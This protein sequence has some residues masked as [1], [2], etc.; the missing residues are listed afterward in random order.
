MAM[1]RE[2]FE[3]L[4]QQLEVQ[5]RDRPAAYER[6][7]MALALLGNA[8]LAAM[9]ALIGLLLVAAVASVVKLGVI[10]VKIALVVG[11]FLAVV[12]QALWVKVPPPDGI[13]IKPADA[14]E[15]FKLIENLRTTLGAPRFHHVLIN[16]DFNAAVVQSPRLGLFGW[17]RN[18]LLIGLPLIKLLSVEQFRAVLAHEFGHLAK[19]HGRMSNWIY[20]LR[21]RW[22]RLV[23][24]LEE[25]ESYGTF[26]FRPFL[27]W[28][29]PYFDAYSYPL[30]RANE[31][32]ADATSARLTS[33][34]AAAEALTG[35]SVYASYLSERFWP[36]IYRQADELPQPAFAP[37]AMLSGRVAVEL[38]ETA[39]ADWL[40]HA[41]AQ[42]TTVDDTHPALHERLAALGEPP[43]LALPAPGKTADRLL[44]PAL[45]A[46]TADFDQRWYQTVLPSWQERHREVQD[47]RSRL[48][49]L[50]ALH[51][52]AQALSPS[53]SIERA[54]LTESVGGDANSALAQ[55]Q[56]LHADG[57]DSAELLHA[58]GARLLALG[59]G[60]GQTML[61]RA[62]AL[63]EHRI[64]AI[65]ELLR[66]DHWQAG[67]EAEAQAWHQRLL[68]RAELEQLAAKERNVLR[69]NE[70]FD[71]HGLSEAQ[72]KELREQLRAVP[73]VR[74]AYLVRKR[75]KHLPH[76]PCHVLGYTAKRAFRFD[77]QQRIA[78]A[79]AGIQTSV[80]LP[81]ETL[82]VNVE[83]ENYRL[84]RTLWWMRGARLL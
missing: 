56:A 67:R 17:D 16:E 3:A 75:V 18:Y 41:L 76:L 81:G 27:R 2:Q 40:R 65:C 47:G 22:G 12:L 79:L 36:G 46:I 8:Y 48:A 71:A 42:R 38:N 66:D 50:N 31:F 64:T 84:G 53:E 14:P 26:L 1:T 10:G 20:R 52:A 21:L 30:A 15:L 45:A 4:V 33:P 83:G 72:L 35:V 49:S 32:Q 5:A 55:L 60:S 61:E 34:R 28:Y 6:H 43:R 62:M 58:L 24:V 51:D 77:N 78:R 73:E 54:V 57:V 74:K 37:L 82:I 19:G 11:G 29:A 7:V 13:E 25:I 9:L 63:D 80:V 23:G 44:E 69:V 70:S 68:E 59:E 39:T